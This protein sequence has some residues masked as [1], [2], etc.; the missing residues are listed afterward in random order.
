VEE[1]KYMIILLKNSLKEKDRDCG[2][3]ESR[4]FVKQKMIK[5]NYM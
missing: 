5:S 1:K 4:V 2:D 3:F